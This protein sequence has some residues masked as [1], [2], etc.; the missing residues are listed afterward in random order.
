MK[1]FTTTFATAAA[2]LTT[3]A[4]LSPLV[5]QA[6]ETVAHETKPKS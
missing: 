5:A 4:A 3:G 1:R 6:Q 2:L